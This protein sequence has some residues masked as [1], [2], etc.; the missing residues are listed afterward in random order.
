MY[1]FLTDALDEL[2]NTGRLQ[3]TIKRGIYVP[4]IYTRV[5][6]KSATSFFEQNGFIGKKKWREGPSHT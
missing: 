3:G 6:L 4:H 5:R 2:I 1:V